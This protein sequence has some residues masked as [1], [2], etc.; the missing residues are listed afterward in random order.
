MP[1]EKSN[2]LKQQVR[3]KLE[4]M[5]GK[6]KAVSNRPYILSFGD[7]KIYL[8]CATKKSGDR[9]WFDVIPSIYE[10]NRADFLVYACGSDDL[11]Y[12]FPR[13]DFAQFIKGANRG[14]NNRP[15]FDIWLD[16]DKFKP[17]GSPQRGYP[18][19]KYRNNFSYL[20]SNKPASE[21]DNQMF[22][23]TGKGW[24][25]SL[26]KK[27]FWGRIDE[28][29]E[30]IDECEQENGRIIV[31]PKNKIWGSPLTKDKPSAG[32][33][34]AFYHSRRAQFSKNDP[35]KRKQRISLIGELIDVKFNNRQMEWFRVA[36]VPGV[37]SCLRSNPIVWDDSTRDLF[38]RCVKD[39]AR[40]G[41]FEADTAAW[42][43]FVVRIN[44]PSKFGQTGGQHPV[45]LPRNSDPLLRA[46][47]ERAA[48]EKTTAHFRQQGFLVQSFEK[49]NVGWDLEATN[50]G[51]KLRL[52]VKGL[53]GNNLTI[54]L[55]PNEFAQMN[56]WQDS[57]RVCAVTN[58]L[59]N[60]QLAIFGFD[61]ASE[62]W[63]DQQKRNLRIEPIIAARCTAD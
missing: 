43:D 44:I 56:Q 46:Q 13:D 6:A 53:S 14:A 35:L 20:N 25:W 36:V 42:S 33:G 21:Y 51:Q 15:Q 62:H 8:R 29:Y 18:I 2:V 32:D 37:L 17:T 41:L 39:G 50:P 10:R 24:L 19:T 23:S 34:F 4:Q 40:A 22:G 5:L 61:P 7:N 28:F 16:T 59:T 38:K 45:G 63:Q 58:A 60:P 49:D 9:F 31:E 48:I 12:V 27:T 57:Y 52:E 55:T 47:I 30:F 26:T 3:N 11:C 54:E 1:T